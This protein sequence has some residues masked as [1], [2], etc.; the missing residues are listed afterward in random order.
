MESNTTNS[1]NVNI[2]EKYFLIYFG[3]EER[4]SIVNAKQIDSKNA[5]LGE[6]GVRWGRSTF[7][8]HVEG[9]GK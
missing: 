4:F 6:V 3:Q 9:I 7:Q 5:A 1:N 2:V 8:G